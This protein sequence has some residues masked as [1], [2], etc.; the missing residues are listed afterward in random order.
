MIFNNLLVAD[1]E[2]LKLLLSTFN[3]H[4]HKKKTEEILHH[5]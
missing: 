4:T 1:D 2:N 5:R 3:K